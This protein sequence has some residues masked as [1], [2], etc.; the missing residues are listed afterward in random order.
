MF[1]EMARPKQKLSEAECVEI[2][3]NEPRGVLAVLGDEGYPYALP[4]DHWYCEED[5]KIYFHSGK[6]GHKIDAIR[7]CDKVSFCVYD[8]GFRKDGD[9]ALNIRS[10]IVFGRVEIV[11]DHEKAIEFTRRLS[12][13]YTSDSEYIERE[14]RD[15]ANRLLCF[16]LVPEHI[17]GKIVKES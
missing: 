11:E 4:I 3:K 7:A 9:W 8:E 2:L 1:R 17:N 6:T 5:G 10:V 16:A 15:Y 12:Y 13:K 14:I